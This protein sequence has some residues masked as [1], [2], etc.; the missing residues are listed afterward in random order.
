MDAAGETLSIGGECIRAGSQLAPRI[1][2]EHRR[3]FTSTQSWRDQRR[4]KVLG[5]GV[6]LPGPPVSTSELLM[7]LEERFGIALVRR[8]TALSNRLRIRTRHLSRDFQVRH[9]TPRRGQIRI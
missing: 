7:R 8:G 2:P 9:E 5:M 3:D 4:L 1:L 6:A